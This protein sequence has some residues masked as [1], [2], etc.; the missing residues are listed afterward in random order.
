[1][2]PHA[3]ANPHNPVFTILQL[4]R[5]AA[6]GD[7]SGQDICRQ[8]HV[9]RTAIWKHMHALRG[10]G[11]EISAVPHRGYRLLTSPNAPWGLEVVPL[12]Q[13]RSLGRDL[14]YLPE[15]ESTNRFL[16]RLAEDGRPE[17]T[18]V[19]ADCQTQG[20][21]RMGR[22]WFSPPGQNLYFSLLL[23]P[24]V[25]PQAVPSLALAMGLAVVR[26]LHK[27]FAK[28]DLGLKWPNDVLLGG[29]KV[30]GILCDMQSEIDRVRC[31][32]VGIGLNVNVPSTA[33]APDLRR[34]A[35]SL[36]DVVAQ[37]ISRPQLL[38]AL[39]L[40]CEHVYDRWQKHGLQPF[41]HELETW[42]VLQNREVTVALPERQVRGRVAG[43]TATGAL[44]LE[45]PGHRRQEIL[46]GDVHVLP[47]WKR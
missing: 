25:Q 34:T 26:V 46:S 20:R 15:V 32:I 40:E 2:L 29:R 9:S 28:L 18:V 45:L 8:L 7:V 19:V 24:G 38:A 31:V 35:V 16:E 23:R 5:Q 44:V 6:G 22:A 13:S 10:L 3:R 41:L 17:G 14:I 21:G 37:E 4:L 12:L 42:S 33:L 43:I 27:S 39:L 11:Y 36:R 30:A 1:M 47:G